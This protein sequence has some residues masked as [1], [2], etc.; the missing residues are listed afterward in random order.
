[1]TNYT[2]QLYSV[3]F[4]NGKQN[5]IKDVHES[6]SEQEY[7]DLVEGN[8]DTFYDAFSAICKRV[9]KRFWNEGRICE[10]LGRGGRREVI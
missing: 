3:Y 10:R 1:M 7:H 8:G 9:E 5:I 6:I 4:S 2:I